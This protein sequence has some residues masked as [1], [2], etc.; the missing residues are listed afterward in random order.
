[1]LRY[2]AF[3]VMIGLMLA[4]VGCDEGGTC[5]LSHGTVIRKT[6]HPAVDEVVGIMM[7]KVVAVVPVH[8]PE[9]YSIDVAGRYELNPRCGNVVETYFVDKAEFDRLK[10]GDVYDLDAPHLYDL[11]AKADS[12]QSSR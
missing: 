3:L 5:S 9:R 2:G 1:M 12:A 10:V 4:T 6:V 11:P 7:P 8:Y